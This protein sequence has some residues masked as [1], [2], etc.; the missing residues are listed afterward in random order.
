[1]GKRWTT[2]NLT[3]L[4][5][6]DVLLM[7]SKRIIVTENR[8][9]NTTDLKRY[10]PHRTHKAIAMELDRCSMIGDCK[11]YMADQH[12]QI[13]FY[14]RRRTDMDKAGFVLKHGNMKLRHGD[15]DY[16]EGQPLGDNT[17]RAVHRK[18][19]PLKQSFNFKV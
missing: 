14:N 1:M 16:V 6:R 18:D 4:S 9:P 8:Q 17:R 12:K 15:I 5:D 2:R 3:G 11:I 13:S 10:L 7:H 19:V